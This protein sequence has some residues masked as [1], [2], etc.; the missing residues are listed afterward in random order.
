[1]SN[2]GEIAGTCDK[3]GGIKYKGGACLKCGDGSV[4]TR[5]AA[6]RDNRLYLDTLVRDTNL[7][8]RLAL[9][10]E[11]LNDED[12]YPSFQSVGCPVPRVRDAV[13][14][15]CRFCSEGVHVNKDGTVVE[16]C[17]KK[18]VLCP[19]SKEPW[20]RVEAERGRKQRHKK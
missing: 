12:G 10:Y 9:G 17:I 19:G 6:A 11:L 2:N 8:D 3:C 14:I 1:M 20:Y 7:G 18:D 4:Q 16:H 13:F 15:V 5:E